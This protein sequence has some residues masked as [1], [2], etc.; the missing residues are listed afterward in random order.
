MDAIC[1]NQQDIDERGSQVQLLP[2]IYRTA[3]HVLVWLGPEADDSVWSIDTLRYWAK[4][5]DYDEVNGKLL[6]R[7]PSDADEWMVQ[8][9]RGCVSHGWRDFTS[10]RAFLDRPWF[11]RL[12]IR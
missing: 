6:L 11:E 8:P 7:E 12:W 5:V 3:A 10:C 1:I 9:Q 4:K 2:L